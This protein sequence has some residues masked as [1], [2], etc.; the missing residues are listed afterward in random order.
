MAEKSM[1]NSKALPRIYHSVIDQRM[2]GVEN[3]SMKAII[4]WTI[5]VFSAFATTAVRGQVPTLRVE[6]YFSGTSTLQT[7]AQYDIETGLLTALGAFSVES[8]RTVRAATTVIQN[9][10]GI[11]SISGFFLIPAVEWNRETA[12][13]MTV[14][15]AR[16]SAASS[17]SNPFINGVEYYAIKATG[18]GLP[19]LPPT[20]LVNI[21]TRAT[22]GADSTVTAGF[23]L[24][25]GRQHRVLIRGVGPQ[26]AK[27]GVSNPSAD[28]VLTVFSEQTQI[29]ANDDWNTAGV[30]LLTAAFTQA[31]AFPL[32]AN[33]RDAG[34]VL[35]LPPGNYSAQV[36]A[37]TP[38]EVLIEVYSLD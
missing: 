25:G 11:S 24:V 26:L 17:G 31:G 27:F 28:T 2:C 3:L 19:I 32:E 1:P 5:I 23:V 7:G 18:E 4:V 12:A 38:G 10:F 22:L 33:S 29:A 36:R 30:A 34:V 35:S 14:G 13:G 8:T 21:A 9:S 37:K 20:R 16:I 15:F 6:R